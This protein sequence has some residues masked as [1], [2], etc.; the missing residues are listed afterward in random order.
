MDG[1]R[2]SL[3]GEYDG[4]FIKYSDLEIMTVIDATPNNLEIAMAAIHSGGSNF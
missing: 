2:E 3:R 4:Q 1:L